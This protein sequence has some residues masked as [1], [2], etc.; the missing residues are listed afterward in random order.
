MDK[1]IVNWDHGDNTDASLSEK[2]L[3]SVFLLSSIESRPIP[4]FLTAT[5]SDSGSLSVSTTADMKQP[6][7]SDSVVHVQLASHFYTWLRSVERNFDI[8]D[9]ETDTHF[10]EY[11]K[12]NKDYCSTILRDLQTILTD[13]KALRENYATVSSKTN[14]LH[15][16]CEHLLQEQNELSETAQRIDRILMHYVN[17]DVV[18]AE[19]RSIKSLL[20]REK[21]K[22]ILDRLDSS[23]NFL[24]LHPHFKESEAYMS[25]A[26]D[27]LRKALQLIN[28]NVIRIVD[29]TVNEL[30][31]LHDVVSPDNSFILLYGR[32]RS[33][34]P[35]IRALVSLVEER[36][37][38]CDEY[39]KALHECHTFYLQRRE[40]LLTPVA[41]SGIAELVDKYQNDHCS[42]LRTG[43]A[44]MVHMCEDESRLFSQFFS[45]RLSNSLNQ[46]L[47][48]LCRCMYDAFRPLIIR[49]SHVEILS[50]LCDIL[51]YELTEE[52]LSDKEVDM[53]AFA[54]LCAT[55]LSDIQDRLTFRAHI[56][57]KTQIL[58]YEPSPGDLSYPE[59]LEMMHD[60]AKATNA[61][62]VAPAEQQPE[63]NAPQTVEEFS[64]T[65][66]DATPENTSFSELAVQPGPNMSLSPADLHGMWYPTVRRT[67][68]FLSKL[69]RCLNADS[70]CG[71]AQE[72]VAMCVQSLVTASTAIAARRT[73]VD[74]QL[75]L[76]KHLL[77]L[78]E[79][80]VPFNVDF[81]VKETSLDF[82]N[83]K[84]AAIGLWAQRGTG[85]F[86]LNRSNALL[87]FLLETPHVVETEVDSR[88]QLDVQ[89]KVTCEA[90]IEDTV[91]NLSGN[92]PE[93]LSKADLVLSAPGAR[94][95]DQAFAHPVAVR[96]L[97]SNSHRIL[98]E[99]LGRT[100][101]TTSTSPGSDRARPAPL[102]HALHT[103]LANPD[104]ESILLRRIRTG[105]LTHWRTLYHLVLDQYSDEDRMIIGC[106]T[107]SQIRLI[108]RDG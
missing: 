75:F 58:G 8:T 23:I 18:E 31:E 85:L 54:E 16:V 70:F 7:N 69:S 64:T 35:K 27:A 20:S 13:L 63:P 50:E 14:S 1:P 80:T 106:P 41:R 17:V 6:L 25:R 108:F 51:K 65:A 88:R 48:N 39:R 95:G 84:D 76:I 38:V 82:S 37:D 10:M 12:R 49:I 52:H 101:K 91:K 89:L 78:R 28:S 81:A 66:G 61:P 104:T 59:K 57:I 107:E 3:E 19:L 24:R 55:L 105:V 53:T 83:Y 47:G 30:M 92:L 29:R 67:L 97:V 43:G 15:D 4:T 72:C 62:T 36:I 96:D 93:F 73:A 99:A 2:Q 21:L 42:L 11:I 56:Y 77:I 90:F 103:Y 26:T 44:F 74:G 86:S 102:W 87:R 40:E 45:P 9:T 100:T 94:L 34:G 46:M 60:I 5:D 71:L 98:C 68:V 79:Q 22:P 32:F 33:Q